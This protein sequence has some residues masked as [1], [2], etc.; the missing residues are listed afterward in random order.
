MSY[1]SNLN[2][3][4]KGSYRRMASALAL[5]L[6]SA[7][8]DV[9]CMMVLP[10]FLLLAAVGNHVPASALSRSLTTLLGQYTLTTTT[11]LV[12]SLFVLRGI[13]MLVLGA[14]LAQLS[15][16]VR[17]K[18]VAQMTVSL[19]GRPFMHAISRSIADDITS[20]T[21]RSQAF[22]TIVVLPLLRLAQDSITIV[23]TLGYLAWFEPLLVLFAGPVLMV[24]GLA[25]YFSIRRISDRQ[26]KKLIGLETQLTHEIT[27]ALGAAREVRIMALAEYFSHRIRNVMWGMTQARGLLGAIYWF[28]R[29]LGELALIVMGIGYMIHKSRTGTA[30]EVVVSN[31]SVLAFAGVRLLPAFAQSMTN[32]VYVRSGREITQKLVLAIDVDR[33][34]LS[35][36]PVEEFTT[37][38][39]EHVD[40]N[41][42]QLSKVSFTYPGNS[43]PTLDCVDLEISGGQSIGLMGQSGAGKSTLADILLGLQGPDSGSIRL[44][45]HP[46]ALNHPIWWRQIGFVAQLP[47]IANET[48]QR[49]IAFG[50]P[51]D[52]IDRQLLEHAIQLAQ[53]QQ[54][55][56]TLPKGLNTML[57]DQGV[58]LSGGQR[59]RVAIA[60]ALYR[61]CNFLLLDEATSALD[62]RTEAEVIK[63][64]SALKGKVATVII[65]HRLST[66]SACDQV[67]ELRDGR[68]FAGR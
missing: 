21:S 68:L 47:Y 37:S 59:Q 36:A 13:Y 29:A 43:V 11:L 6:G 30:T 40:F 34:L 32:V 2:T 23:A 45:G 28:P 26:S 31:L 46:V 44:N 7:A 66:L 18:V 22:S 24:V 56:A 12:M 1:L 58:R 52:E 41:T 35:G 19:L 61:K 65:A 4:L 27:Q 62:H 67:F 10:A 51:D 64:V 17:E 5:S 53:L 14:R 20:A 42:L 33:P 54:V 49:N 57:G 55:V 8:L 15:E 38:E 60:R 63:S 25:Y 39:L 16:S 48:L 9:L 3:L 50:I